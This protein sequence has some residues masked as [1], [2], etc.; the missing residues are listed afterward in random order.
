MNFIEMQKPTI[1]ER[2]HKLK[3]ELI[4]E[5][6]CVVI[7]AVVSYAM[8]EFALPVIL[9]MDYFNPIAL[10][11]LPPFLFETIFIISLVKTIVSYH[12]VSQRIFT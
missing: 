2:R 1:D 12:D 3:M 8:I 6:S 11:I 7:F 10:L 9:S 5:A 4:T